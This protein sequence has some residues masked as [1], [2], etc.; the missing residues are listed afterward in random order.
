MKLFQASDQ[1]FHPS[2]QGVLTFVEPLTIGGVESV[3]SIGLRRNN[4][5]L[6]VLMTFV[7]KCCNSD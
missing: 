7:E 4:H 3:C 1:F 2:L 5:L 6:H